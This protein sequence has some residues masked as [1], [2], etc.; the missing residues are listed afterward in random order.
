MQPRTP[1]HR[2]IIDHPAAWT[3]ATLGADAKKALTY[4]LTAEQRAAV[5]RVVRKVAGMPVQAIT[6]AHVDEPVFEAMAREL[7]A[8]LADGRGLL[9]V[10]GVDRQRY[11][12]DEC[13]R[14]FWALGTYLGSPATQNAKGQQITH[15]T[16][17][18]SH[19]TERGYRSSAELSPHTDA[20]A[21]LGLFCLERSESGGYSHAAS[22]LAVHNEILRTRPDLL[23]ALYHGTRYAAMDARGTGVEPTRENIPLFSNVDGKV[24]CFFSRQNTN[25]AVRQT[26][27]PLEPA[28]AEAADLFERLARDERFRIEFMLEPGEI[29]LVNNYVLVHA[30]TEFEDSERHKRDLLRLWLNSDPLRPVIPE[31]HLFAQIYKDIFAL[32]AN[33]AN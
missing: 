7:E 1:I 25:E 11:N 29:M 2:E 20:Y 19:P 13:E 27:V 6:R 33:A 14:L 22:A 10:Q 5:E 16:Q 17:D 18:K 8:E 9:V 21:I 26:G 4:A 24:S 12:D 28:F 31:L 15:V 3:P 30:R 32:Q 23:P